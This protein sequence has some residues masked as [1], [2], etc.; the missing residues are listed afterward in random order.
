MLAPTAYSLSAVEEE[1]CSPSSQ[2]MGLL[3]PRGI[4][5]SSNFDDFCVKIQR[6]WKRFKR[7]FVLAFLEKEPGEAVL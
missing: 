3:Y 4:G 5:K 2:R 7:F 1:T 6:R